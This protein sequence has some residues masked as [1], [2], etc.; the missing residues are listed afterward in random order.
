[1]KKEIK[2]ILLAIGIFLITVAFFNQS[3][4]R[5]QGLDTGESFF[6]KFEPETPGPNTE[7]K[8]ELRSYSFDADRA[9]IIWSV[10]GEV[11]LEGR[12]KKNFSFKTGDIG[13]HTSLNISVI[14]QTGT[15]QS[16]S[17]SFIPADIDFIWEAQTYT[18]PSYKG[19]A[20]PVAGSTVKITAIPRF[21]SGTI[22]KPSNYIYKWQLD[23][24]NYPDQSGAGKNS[25]ILKMD[26]LFS[27]KTISVEASDYQKTNIAKK[28]IKIENYEPKINFYEE[29][30][31]EGTQYNKAIL[32][33]FELK[34]PEINIKAEPYFFS[35]NNLPQLS[36]HWKM[37]NK[38]IDPKESKPYIVNLKVPEGGLGTSL[39]DLRIENPSSIF[40]AAEKSLKIKF[41]R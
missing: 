32:G 1:M 10:N 3:C 13:T 5:G 34:A 31:L 21:N 9:Y 37:N 8:A 24:K 30:P 19:K 39:I 7:V 29:K 25:F 4:V 2:Q 20:L 22:P 40:Q 14:P 23:F 41:G 12:G 28:S 35:I 38:K 17:F 33:E 26:N 27:K 16:K 6:V 15:S 18:P 36:Y 11:W